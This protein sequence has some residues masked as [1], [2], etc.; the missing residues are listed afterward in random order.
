MLSAGLRKCVLKCSVRISAGPFSN[1]LGELRDSTLM[2]VIS[3]HMTTAIC[4]TIL[5]F[6]ILASPV[7]DCLDRC[8][9]QP[10]S[11]EQYTGMSRLTS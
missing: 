5:Y 1:S 6:L 10:K 3:S 8:S 9:E 4:A 11:Q 2:L 7:L